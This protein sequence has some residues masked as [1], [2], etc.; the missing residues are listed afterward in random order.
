MKRFPIGVTTTY[1]EHDETGA[2]RTATAIFQDIS[3]QKRLDVAAPARRAARGHRRAERVA[4]A[5]DQESARVDPQRGRAD[6]AHAGDVA[7]IRKRSACLVMRE[8]DRL[9]RL[10]SEFLDFARVRVARTEPVDLADDRA[11]RGEP[12]LGASRSRRDRDASRASRRPATSSMI[13]GDEDLLHRAVFNLALNAVQASPPDSEVRV[14]VA[15]GT[16]RADAARA[17]V[18]RRAR[19]RSA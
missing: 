10:L 9:S 3:D 1:T 13:D 17:A 6:L 7:T 11:R 18:R 2:G 12:R 15:R 8:S 19:C 14:E 4:R 5:R 16:L